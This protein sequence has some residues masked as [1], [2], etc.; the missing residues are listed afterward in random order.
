VTIQEGRDW[1]ALGEETVSGSRC[2]VIRWRSGA[3]GVEQRLIDD[4][5]LSPRRQLQFPT[6]VF[7]CSDSFLDQLSRGIS[8]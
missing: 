3:E 1:E 5:Y 7:H 6:G 4:N 2:A 8:L